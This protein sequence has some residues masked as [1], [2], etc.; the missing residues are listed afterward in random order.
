M[1]FLSKKLLLAQRNRKYFI[2]IISSHYS[3]LA[4][5]TLISLSNRITTLHSLLQFH[6]IAIT[7]G[8][9]TNPFIASKLIS[10]YH[11][12]S[13]SSAIFL[14]LPPS[15]A[16]TFLWNSIIKSHFSRADY[17]HA[18]QFYSLMRCSDVLPDHF[19][20]PMVA[21][22]YAHLMMVQDGTSLHGLVSK[23]GLFGCNSAVGSS[24]VSLYSRCGLMRDACLVFDE[25]LVRDVVAWTALVVGFV[26]NGESE[27]GLRCVREMML[28]GVDSERP[29]SR[30]LEGG[31]LAC[32]DLV[33]L[34]E[35]RC[36]HG[37]VVKTGIGCEQVVQSSLLSMY[38]R[39]GVLQEAYQSFS[40]VI[41]K[42]L[43][44]WTSIIGVYARFGMVNECVRLFWKMLENQVDPDGIVLGCILSAFG[45]SVNEY[46]AKA[47]HGFI[48]RRHYINDDVVHN[49][50]LFM[51]CK[52]GMLTLAERLFNNCQHSLECWNYMVNGYGR[53]GNNTK[54]VEL[55]R[56]MHYLGIDSELTSIVSAIGS[57]AELGQTNLGRSI[58]CN[59]VKGFMDA[60]VL[61]A[62]SLI[63]MY[64]KCDKMTYAWKV[65]K[66]LDKDVISWNTM[67]SAHI[68][69][70]D[71]KEA[72]KLFNKMINEG[73]KPNTAT[74][75]IVL[76]ACSHI[77]SLEEGERVHRY[78][79]ERGFE[80]N[81]PLGTALVDM[82]A[83][84]G[85]LEKSRQVFDSMKEKDIVCWNAMISGYGMNGYAESALDIF[86]HMEKSNVKP[87]GVTFL[88]LLSACAHA[89]LVEEGKHLFA[90]MPCYSVEPNLKH[91]TCMIDILGRSG[92]LQE[93]EA[94]VLSMPI[95]P[96]GGVWGALLSACK[97]YNQVEMGIRVAMY[98]IESEPENDGYYM[99]MANMYS[100]IGRW[101]EAENVRRTMKERCSLGKKAG[102]S[103]L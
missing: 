83:K 103:V 98:A 11:N 59:A 26:H 69:V 51:Y 72:T 10:L 42:D 88:G 1:R 74:F 84:C 23:C 58:H 32:G 99:M 33:A 81:L 77:A 27:K 87:N 5:H 9:S 61:V 35:G 18:L 97:T 79:N 24:F 45:Y 17:A 44:S 13:S 53:I 80:L 96:D 3:T 75:A 56:E 101:E 25:M 39:C 38:C 73:H 95:H 22:S 63:Q 7:T 2:S 47:F 41:N 86:K 15:S 4:S 68:H 89:G 28:H 29:N 82:Y 37:F 90:K 78:I 70:K 94:L 49:S 64:G 65:F 40:E 71:Y 16:D 67:I 46:E 54:C 43:V 30:T 62:N 91:H 76:S 34:S 12:P 20:V 50:L 55:F 100:S 14:S 6:A 102:W 92:N 48:I 8:N 93:A 19:T 36:L 52:L 21:S 66:R 57:C 31:L 60:N 85:K